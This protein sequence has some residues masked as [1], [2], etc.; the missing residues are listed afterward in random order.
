MVLENI[1]QLGQ[2]FEEQYPL[3]KYSVPVV[4]LLVIIIFFATAGKSIADEFGKDSYSFLREKCKGLRKTPSPKP[5]PDISKPIA[6]TFAV[7][8]RNPN[9]TGREDI[10]AE[11]RAALTSGQVAAW[12]QALT[13]LGGTGKSQIA[14]EYAYRHQGDYQF[15]WWL[16]SEEP[17]AL[18]ANYAGLAFDLKLPEKG[19]ADQTAIIAAVN[20]WLG[21]NR[22]W[23]L[24]FDN[25]VTPEDIVIYLPRDGNGHVIVTTRNP[26]WR[27]LAN[28]IPIKEFKREESIE[29]LGRRTKLKNKEDASLLA[30]ALG[31]LPLALEQ[32]GAYIGESGISLADY[33]KLFKEQRDEILRRGKPIGYPDTIATAWDI[34]FKAVQEKSADSI[35]LLKILA[36]LAPNNIPKSMLIE[37]ASELPE[38]LSSTAKDG[39]RFNDSISSLRLYSLISIADNSLSIHRLVQAVMLDGLA[40]DEKKKW[41]EAAIRMVNKAFIFD[42]YDVATWPIC[43][44][45]L[46]HALAAV[47]FTEELDEAPEATGRLL[48]K[49][50]SYLH[51]RA[52][53]F[54][55]KKNFERAL[56]IFQNH[57]G[58]NHPSTRTVRNN[59]ESLKNGKY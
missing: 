5:S 6:L 7:P 45:L 9:F 21:E 57:L 17:T 30:N 46:P 11:L 3:S 55:A 13:G 34:S 50:G 49:I 48:N 42:K 29:F 35:D 39:I 23:L 1:S 4:I 54:E 20:R 24:I 59:L 53:F 2:I 51:E 47:K 18:A 12:K 52:E 19:L 43:S 33:L 28:E 26:N 32:A 36:F 27:G 15:I 56:R 37:G 38:P 14:T 40:E 31:D 10:L 8:Q 25:V 16:E 58:E 41:N 44:L 22:N